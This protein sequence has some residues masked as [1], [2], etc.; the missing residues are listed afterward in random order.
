MPNYQKVF[1]SIYCK[2]YAEN[3]SEEMIDRYATGNE[4]YK[5]LMK[6]AGQCFDESGNPIPRDYNIWYLGC[7]EKFGHLQ[8]NDKIW[9]WGLGESSFDNVEEFVSTLYE[10]DLITNNQF[11]TLIGEI[12]EGRQ[13][14]NMYHIRGYLICKRDGLQW[15]KRSD[16]SAFRNTIKQMVDDVEKSFQKRGFQVNFTG[17]TGKK[18]T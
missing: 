3:F 2:I 8:L 10:K 4:I 7:N 15:I 11:N 5:F 13:I 16:A 6:D 17:K 18:K 9:K 14:D 1:V 12:E